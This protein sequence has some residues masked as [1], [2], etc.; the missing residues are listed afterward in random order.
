MN[1]AYKIRYYFPHNRITLSNEN[2]F[3]SSFDYEFFV[4]NTRYIDFNVF[5]S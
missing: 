2:F 1:L 4:N 5:L 3:K